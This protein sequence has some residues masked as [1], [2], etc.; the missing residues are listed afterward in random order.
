[1]SEEFYEA[2]VDE[3]EE[4]YQEDILAGG[5]EFDKFEVQ[6]E[7]DYQVGYSQMKQMTK[8]GGGGGQL[9][10][11]FKGLEKMN[12]QLI[13]KETLFLS[14][15][16][17]ELQRYLDS[18]DIT[19]HYM[20]VVEKIPRYWYKNIPALIS[21]ILMDHN[22]STNYKKYGDVVGVDPVDVYRYSKLLLNIK[23]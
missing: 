4:E 22:K 21:V 8:G 12:L 3:P 7:P 17:S 11:E 1:M 10:G 2:Y 13:S 6:D 19:D 9:G 15:L 23:Y 16:Y 5:D 18:Y 20:S 14:K